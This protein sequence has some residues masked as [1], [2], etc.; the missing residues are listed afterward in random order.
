MSLDGALKRFAVVG[1]PIAHSLSP[2]IHNE[3]IRAA[4]LGAEYGRIRL[5]SQQAADDLRAMSAEYSGLNVTLPHKLAALK[6]AA[7]ADDLALQVGA[8]NTLVNDNGEWTA[9]N[10][11]V[12]GFSEAVRGALGETP[13]GLEV[14]LI[15]A[16]GAARAALVSLVGARARIR[17][18]NRTRERAD[19][20]AGELAPGALTGGLEALAGFAR[21][22]DLIVNSASLGHGGADLPEL[23]PGGGRVFL[24]LSYGPAAASA[25]RAA[26][27][28]GWTPHDGLAMLVAQA[29]GAFRLWFGRDPNQAQAL[30]A[31][32]ARLAGPHGDQ[33]S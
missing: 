24:D 14:V 7:R 32:R 8:A 17:I 1:D 5:V 10:T 30:A 25:L 18:V 23:G 20:L 29:A 9:W 4:G 16:G 11:D 6:A 21:T 26:A 12:G 19:A 33:P 31:C 2:L 15:G 22:A 27:V 28:S 3:W 13:S